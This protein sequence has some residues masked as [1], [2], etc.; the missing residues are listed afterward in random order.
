MN[1]DTQKLT[2]DAPVK[3]RILRYLEFERRGEVL[4]VVSAEFDFS[5]CPGELHQLAL[6]CLQ[7]GCQR[8]L[9]PGKD[10]DPPPS[11]PGEE[12]RATGLWGRLRAYFR[13]KR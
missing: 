4:G 9:L 13:G 2:A 11:T 7:T 3:V 6:T 8:V 1:T 5:D 12:V 10:P